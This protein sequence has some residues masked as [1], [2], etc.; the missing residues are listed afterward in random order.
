MQFMLLIHTDPALLRALPQEEYDRL[1]RGC[2]AH[3]DQMK[4]DGVLLASQQL[5]DPDAA[6]SV[7]V[8]AGKR[9]VVDGPFAE[10]K[11]LLA[12]F[13]LIEARDL[14]EAVRIADQF[15][16]AAVGCIEVRPVRDMNAVRARVGAAAG[17]LELVPE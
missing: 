11:E 2:F 3:A 9:S 5:E 14:D 15:P 16:W 17:S 8:R 10:T 4:R 12:G 13:N 7:R 1:M 6:R